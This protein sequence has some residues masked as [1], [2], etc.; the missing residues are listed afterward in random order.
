L[1]KREFA[2]TE[3]PRLW[4]DLGSEEATKAD[5]A[6]W[7]LVTGRQQSVPFLK[8]QLPPAKRDAN[9]T[10]KLEKLIADLDSDE[11]AVREKARAELA[12][13]GLSAEPALKKAL[14]AKPSLEVRRR[15]EALLEAMSDRCWPDLSLQSWRALAVLERIGDDARQVLNGLAKGDPDASLT[16]KAKAS[17]E[18][19]QRRGETPR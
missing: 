10:A 2:D 18:R 8:V 11:F 16:Q 9:L 6:L 15:I 5:G 3:L 4:A 17:L 13:L 19:L 12:K 7:T 1:A 14:A